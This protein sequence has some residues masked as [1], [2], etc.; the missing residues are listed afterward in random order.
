MLDT[1]GH[2][3]TNYH[4]IENARQIEV[5]F[6][7]ETTLPA[8]VVGGDPRNDIAVLQVEAPPGL[9]VPVELGRSDNLKVGQ[10]AIVIGNPVWPVWRHA[11]RWG[12]QRSESH[13]GEPGWAGDERDYSNRCG[14]QSR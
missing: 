7:D 13:S 11:D 3:L 4:V 10:R 5:I 14:Y 8:Q 2:I 6:I 9:L 12:Y 1:E